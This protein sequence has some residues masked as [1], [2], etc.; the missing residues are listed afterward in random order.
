MIQSCFK[1]LFA[2]SVKYSDFKIS[3]F[4]HKM[5]K[6]YPFRGRGFH[7]PVEWKIGYYVIR[8][9]IIIQI[10]ILNIAFYIYGS[11]RF[12]DISSLNLFEQIQENT[13]SG[14]AFSARQLGRGFHTRPHWTSNYG[15]GIVFIG[16]MLLWLSFYN[17]VWWSL[18]AHISVIFQNIS[19]LFSKSNR[20]IYNL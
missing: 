12:K 1:Y 7:T 11:M 9:Q 10:L 3:P 19:D 16:N 20:S 4:V 17:F 14:S 15:T 13:I 5:A 6:I 2:T 18:N 8:K